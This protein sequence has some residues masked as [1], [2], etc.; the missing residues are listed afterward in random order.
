MY[1]LQD[2]LHDINKLSRTSV[3][4]TLILT[5]QVQYIMQ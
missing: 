1:G 4:I 5:L 2:H 3:I